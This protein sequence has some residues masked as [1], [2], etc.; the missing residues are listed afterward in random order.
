MGNCDVIL[1]F[2][3]AI[4]YRND[5]GAPASP[6]GYLHFGDTEWQDLQAGVTYALN[7]GA[8]HLVLYGWS[9]GG[10]IVEAFMHRSADAHYVQAL[11][12][13]AP[14]LDLRSTL[15]FQA[16]QQSV[17]GFIDPIAEWIASL[18]SGLNFDALDN[19]HEPQPAIPV[20]LFHGTNDTTTP[21]AVSDAFAHAHP[22]F[23]TYVRVL[24]AEHTEAWNT[25]PQAYDAAL[26]AF[27][28]QKLDL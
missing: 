5:L 28:T 16:Q 6:D 17:P 13:D 11:V 15:A 20:L 12:L 2:L 14:L 1:L 19:L 7:H 9:M 3:L 27:L 22:D 10:A 23:V 18:R 24:G 4:S 25:N 21:I 26:T 8:Q